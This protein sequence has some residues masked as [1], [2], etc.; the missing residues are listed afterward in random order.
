MMPD[1]LELMLGSLSK[2]LLAIPMPWR[3]AL[4]TAALAL[5]VYGIVYGILTLSLSLEFQLTNRLRRWNL[6]PVPGT[7]IFDDIV[8]WTIRL[9]SVLKWMLLIISMLGVIAWYARPRLPD[10][11]YVQYIDQFIS[12]WQFLEDKLMA[13]S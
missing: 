10:A 11:V 2:L 1:F 9:F 3:A 12:W 7:Y 8:E 5:V 6:R 4:T 13:S